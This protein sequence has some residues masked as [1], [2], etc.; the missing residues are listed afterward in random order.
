MTAKTILVQIRMPEQLVRTIDSLQDQGIYTSRTEVIMDGV[1]RLVNAY[2]TSDPLKQAV[3][4][5]LHGKKASISFRDI[6]SEY[7]AEEV[8]SSLKKALK[9]SSI[10]TIIDEG[11]R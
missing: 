2:Q 4:R 9:T 5:S 10:D 3:I 7:D 1:R 8:E 11:R 6:Q